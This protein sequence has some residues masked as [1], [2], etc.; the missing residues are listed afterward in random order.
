[1]ARAKRDTQR[2]ALYKAERE[3]SWFTEDGKMTIDEVVKYS[4]KIFTSKFFTQNWSLVKSLD[5][6]SGK[7]CKCA[8]GGS[9]HGNQM[10][11]K[12]PQWSRSKGVIIHELAHGVSK[13]HWG[14]G[15]AGHGVEYAAVYLNGYTMTEGNANRPAM[16]LKVQMDWHES[17]LCIGSR[18]PLSYE[19][20][21]IGVADVVG[22]ELD[23]DTV[24]LAVTDPETQKKVK[25]KM[26]AIRAGFSI[27]TSKDTIEELA[28]NTLMFDQEHQLTQHQWDAL[29][30]MIGFKSPYTLSDKTALL[31]QTKD[32]VNE[33]VFHQDSPKILGSQIS[34]WNEKYDANVAAGKSDL[35][36]PA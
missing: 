17:G 25:Q 34:D 27:S 36:P 20:G 32:A 14:D 22:L 26:E 12:M 8:W 33:F 29:A 30:C 4:Y 31:K 28:Y 11:I 1:M 2:E 6:D 5:V 3:C 13:I 7:R 23:P 15:I 19:D 35:N 21:I 18:Y 9:K 24:I 10:W 16:K